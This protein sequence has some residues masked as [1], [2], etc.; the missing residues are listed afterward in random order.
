[1]R[2]TNFVSLKHYPDFELSPVQM[3]DSRLFKFLQP[4]MESLS[5]D[6]LVLFDI[7]AL[8]GMRMGCLLQNKMHLKPILTYANPLHPYGVVG[9]DLY[10]NA[11]VGFGQELM[12]LSSPRAYVLILDSLRYRNRIGPATLLKK[13]NNQYELT[14]DDLPTIEMLGF[15]QYTKM[16]LYRLGEAKED[17]SAYIQYIKENGLTVDEIELSKEIL[18]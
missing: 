14:E 18:R 6:H 15:L 2:K 5:P 3:R 12:P 8:A 17:T 4:A 10:V 13:F 1:M 9:G 11:L 7:P 16:T